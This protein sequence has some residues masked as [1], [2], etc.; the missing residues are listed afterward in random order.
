MHE[1]SSDALCEWMFSCL[2]QG[3]V[4]RRVVYHT[5]GGNPHEHL[6]HHEYPLSP[7]SLRTTF[8]VE[9]LRDNVEGS[10]VY[11]AQSPV[12]ATHVQRTGHGHIPFASLPVGVAWSPPACHQH[13][14][15]HCAT[16][17][18]R[19]NEAD[20]R[21]GGVH[22]DA[23]PLT[24][25]R[26]FAF[27]ADTSRPCPVHST[28]TYVTSFDP[29][30]D[31]PFTR[32]YSNVRGHSPYV[33][34]YCVQTPRY[35]YSCSLPSHFQGLPFAPLVQPSGHHHCCSAVFQDGLHDGRY[36]FA[37]HYDTQVPVVPDRQ[38]PAAVSS[39]TPE[40]PI[41]LHRCED[42]KFTT[43]HSVAFPDSEVL[44]SAEE[45][46]SETDTGTLVKVCEKEFEAEL[47]VLAESYRIRDPE[48]FFVSSDVMIDPSMDDDST[49]VQ[50]NHFLL[51]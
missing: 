22:D 13:D 15:T 43:D 27:G 17:P 31:I 28:E 16:P 35:P 49:P 39:G 42:P 32:A 10:V 1:T 33:P 20:T 44:L 4:A 26:Q 29:T 40:P 8:D 9:P 2:Q 12:G 45:A 14:C 5:C 21:S 30:F 11:G 37:G 46:S 18:D 3:C 38:F 47:P 51:V 19:R 7:E 41:H 24:G 23:V 36:H 48:A 34:R 6:P 50:G 25:A